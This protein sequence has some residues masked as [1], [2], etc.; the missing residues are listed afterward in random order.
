MIEPEH[1]DP[2][3]LGQR[4]T[5]ARKAR[6]LTQEE[7]ATHLECSRPT[8]IA[9]EKG[10]R[11]AKPDEIIKL[12]AYYGRSVH[13]LVR[14]GVETVALEPHLRAV[15]D[16]ASV[17]QEEMNDAIA[18]LEHFAEDYRE[19]ER[20]LDAKLTIANPPTVS[21]PKRGSLADFGEDAAIRERERLGLGNQPILNLRQVL[22]SD[23]GLRVF[24]GGLPSK[25]AG[26]FAYTAELGFCVFIN[27]KHPSERR[28][29]TLAHEY[30]HA[31]CDRHKPGIDY[32]N[33]Q[34]RKPASERFAEAFGLGF[35]MPAS[36]VRR[37]FH[38]ITASTGDFQ[39]ADLCRLS[40]YYWVSVQAMTLRL[41]ELGLIAK[42]SWNLLAER[43]FKPR[44][45]SEDLGLAHRHAK[46]DDPYPQRYMFLAVQ[47]FRTGKISE[48][49]LSKFLRC[50]PVG[51]REIVAACLEQSFV[52]ADG[53]VLARKMPFEDSLLNTRP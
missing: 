36:S 49:Q 12:A 40:I 20:L 8:L 50:D 15:V 41:E 23:V 6:G 7:A 48:G 47:A 18:E 16:P 31:L 2:R 28:R 24:Y 22:E 52:D 3:L 27:R 25:I 11:R 37:K 42:G 46:S 53:Q 1:D 45:A 39:V 34:G 30:G 38:E 9:I 32:I 17:P 19:L 43:G 26:M 13:E 29:A 44:K 21:L 33:A 4:L 10:E 51:A 35:L 5:A 14:P